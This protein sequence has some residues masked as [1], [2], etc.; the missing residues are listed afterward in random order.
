MAT[1]PMPLVIYNHRVR[2]VAMVNM[3]FVVAGIWLA[4]RLGSGISF[5]LPVIFLGLFS[6]FW[7][8]DLLFG[9][10]L[11]LV[12]DGVTLRWQDDKVKGSVALRD[13]RRILI[14]ETIT[15]IGDG[16][17]GWT[18]IRFELRSGSTCVLPPN[19][20]RG[21]S[22][23]KWRRLKHLVAHIRTVGDVPVE[24]INE[25]GMFLKRWKDD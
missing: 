24:A 5:Y 13:I 6:L 16:V 1:E 22:A 4:V 7:I 15:Q 11:M 3:T 18:Y 17:I 12:S 10:R 9:M 20:A 25:P 21:L 23:R 2:W 14:G 8:R 19:I